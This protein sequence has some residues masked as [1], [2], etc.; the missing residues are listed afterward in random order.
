M[1]PVKHQLDLQDPPALPG[2]PAKRQ[3]F[4]QVALPKASGSKQ[5]QSSST[6]FLRSAI[7]FPVSI[8]NKIREKIFD[9][10]QD[11]L[12]EFSNTTQTEPGY[13][14]IQSKQRSF[15]VGKRTI[16]VPKLQIIV[17]SSDNVTVYIKTSKLPNA[18]SKRIAGGYKEFDHALSLKLSPTEN[19]IVLAVARLRV[20]LNNNVSHETK[21][22]EFDREVSIIKMLKD[23]KSLCQLYHFFS[24]YQGKANNNLIIKSVI[25]EELCPEGDLF[26]YVQKTLLT[27]EEPE[28]L[29]FATST[30]QKILIALADFHKL[31][32]IHRDI[33]FENF[34]VGPDKFKLCDFG[35]VLRVGEVV[36]NNTTPEYISPERMKKQLYPD[37]DRKDSGLSQAMDIWST[38]CLY[39]LLQNEYFPPFIFLQDIF[40]ILYYLEITMDF[41]KDSFG[42]KDINPLERNTK[43]FL[44]NK[45]K[46][47]QNLEKFTKK[48]HEYTTIIRDLNPYKLGEFSLKQRS[49]AIRLK[50]IGDSFKPYPKIFE[51]LQGM[52]LK[53]IQSYHNDDKEAQ[54]LNT[55]YI[56][57][58][59][60]ILDF[61]E[62]VKMKLKSSWDALDE[63]PE[64][65]DKQKSLL[66][67]LLRPN[68]EQRISAQTALDIMNTW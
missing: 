54:D 58:K 36:D 52:F 59:T 34:L 51:S 4:D 67:K 47:V 27:L 7:E 8:S 13:F 1:L 55:L 42:S 60:S 28:R 57:L 30:F 12:N 43:Q 44:K 39:Y 32:Y 61:K 41:E 6:S 29:R 3:R 16:K 17:E 33:K 11:C 63:L 15:K 31:N 5:S 64:P 48:F 50:E 9:I 35:S 49:K 24:R 21:L 38:G 66:W 23:S 25:Y 22:K 40:L 37:D 68:P 20:V 26:D 56:S 10:A 65:E 45:E 53:I 14:N 19:P 18:I 46:L 2:P 62:A